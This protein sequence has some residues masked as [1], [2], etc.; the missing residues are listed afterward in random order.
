MNIISNI[1]PLYKENPYLVYEIFSVD[2]SCC[3]KMQH[4]LKKGYYSLS[5]RGFRL[6]MGNLWVWSK[7]RYCPFCGKE[8]KVK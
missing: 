1:I 5:K 4:L 3:R 7:L 2:K 6:S 8:I